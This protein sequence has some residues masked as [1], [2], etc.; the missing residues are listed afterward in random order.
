MAHRT[1]IDARHYCTE[2]SLRSGIRVTIRAVSPDDQHG[3]VKAFGERDLESVRI[4]SFDGQR[5]L[6]AG[7]LASPIRGDLPQVALGLCGGCG[8]PLFSGGVG[9]ECE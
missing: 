7:A 2:E 8:Q 6:G 9:D 3:L 1:I 5:E 4:R